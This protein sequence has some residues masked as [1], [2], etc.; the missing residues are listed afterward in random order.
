MLVFG[1]VSNNN[2]DMRDIHRFDFGIVYPPD[3]VHLG[4]N[5]EKLY[6]LADMG[7]SGC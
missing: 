2:N 7:I 5:D 1:G 4:A 3:Y 6:R